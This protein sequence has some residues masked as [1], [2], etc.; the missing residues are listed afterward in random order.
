MS[1]QHER[2]F[3]T[4]AGFRRPRE[5]RQDHVGTQT[6]GNAAAPAGRGWQ[7]S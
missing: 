1:R 6:D 4:L 3:Q 2:V 7:N 5:A